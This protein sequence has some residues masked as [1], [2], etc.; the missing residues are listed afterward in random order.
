MILK[1]VILSAVVLVGALG[2]ALP[3]ASNSLSVAPDLEWAGWKVLTFPGKAATQF[4]GRSDGAIE[5]TAKGSASLLYHEVAAEDR[6]AR[7]LSWRWRIDKTMAPTDL[8][9]KGRDDRPLAVHVWFA[10]DEEADLWRRLRHAVFAEILGAPLTGK[11]L[12]YVW[13]GIGRPGDMVINPYME[14]DGVMFILRPGDVPTGRWFTE[15]IDILADFELA[16]GYPA[17]APSYIA[18]SADADD[19]SSRSRG[20]IAEIVFTER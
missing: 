13:G 11:V 20:A 9:R 15:K 14:M 19:T 2:L 18:V 6:D 5:V 3:A 16:F 17:P 10:D 4:V 12:T 1:S 8:S 7:Y